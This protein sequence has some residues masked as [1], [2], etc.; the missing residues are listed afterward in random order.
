MASFDPKQRPSA[1]TGFALDEVD[2]RIDSVGPD[3]GPDGLDKI[4][5]SVIDDRLC[6]ETTNEL[7]LLR[8]A[9]DCH[10][11]STLR[12]TDLNGR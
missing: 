10:D 7:D 6:S 1:L 8:T 2:D 3:F 9:G 4:F 5:G 11:V 12:Q